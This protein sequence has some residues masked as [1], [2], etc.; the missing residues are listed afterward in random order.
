LSDLSLLG[1]FVFA[2]E[3]NVLLGI[4]AGSQRLLAF[5]ALRDRE[6]PHY[7]VA[8]TLWPRASDEQASEYLRTAI[9]GLNSRADETVMVTGAD[10]RL[11]D[12]MVIDVHY[13]ESLARRLLDPD[14]PPADPD[15]G[16]TAVAA[17]SEDLLPGWYDH[18][19][20]FAAEA[21]HQLR[22]HALETV[23]A[24]LTAADRLAEA[25]S[26]ARAAVQAEPL[27]ESARAALI[28]VFLA[29]GQRADAVDEFERY[30]ALLQAEVGIE[31]TSLLSQLVS[32]DE[33]A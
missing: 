18:W 2:V 31:P 7:E 26:A 32:G 9:F 28:R 4:P 6:M 11:G 13:A 5:L 27:R 3:G 24:R 21:W 22:M 14:A 1:G 23:A 15:T 25:A 10:L 8:R 33:P 29:R 19:A 16:A 20:L 12:G 30:R 17:L